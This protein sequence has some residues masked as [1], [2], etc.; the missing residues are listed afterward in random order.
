MTTVLTSRHG[1]V[2]TLSLNRPERL[3]AVSEELYGDTIDALRDA[4][5]DPEIRSVVLTGAGRAF[6]VG[7]DLKA[8]KSGGRSTE[9]QAHYLDLGQRVC[10]QIQKMSTPVIAA[11]NG[12]ALGAGAEMAVS[13]DFLVIAEDAKMGFPEVSIGT[14]VGGGV[15]NRLPRLVGLRRATE[16]LILGERFTGVQA[17]EWGL[18]YKSVPAESLLDE[19]HVLAAA[20]AGKA[21]LSLARM[22]AALLRN[23]DLETVLRTEPQE[24]L[25]LMST[26]DWAEGVASFAEKRDPVFQ[27]K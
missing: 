3:N 25:A 8:H 19:A 5:A 10:E 15:T 27:G 24:L 22:K 17:L 1:S 4:D 16:M 21:P 6:C 13:A 7:A 12:Y 2:L 14:F 20:L 9:A 26:S 23:D 18:A 11:V